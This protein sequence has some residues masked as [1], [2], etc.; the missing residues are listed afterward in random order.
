MYFKGKVFMYRIIGQPINFRKIGTSNLVIEPPSE[1]SIRIIKIC[2]FGLKYGY[3]VAVSAFEISKSTYYNYLKLY[4]I[5]QEFSISLELKS[6]KPHNLRKANWDKRIIWFIRKMRE[7]YANI[8]K[9]K[10]KYYLDKYCREKNI[11]PVST[12]T[13]QN[14]INSFPNKL[15]TKKSVIK[16]TRRENVVRK[17]SNYKALHSGECRALD[18]M[19]FRR[20]GKKLYVVVAQ[21]EATNLMY[22]RGTNSH[23]SRSAKEILELAHNYLPWDKYNIILTDNGSEFGKDFAKYVKEQG[24]VHYH[25]YPRTPKQNAR[26][27]RVNRTIQDEFMIKYGNLLFDDIHLFNKKLDKY[28][29]WYNFERVHARFS[30]KI[31]PFER[32]RQLV[33]DGKII[34]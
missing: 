13:I 1:S 17:P 7:E 9:D 11:K 8:G 6:K 24:A 4:K 3:A 15:R 20:D 14:I 21:D 26:C 23:T 5:S 18:S 12:G 34:G 10:I 31:T 16:V 28:L 33:N 27:E 29:R 32:H 2:E 25:T 22:A 19:E 30:N